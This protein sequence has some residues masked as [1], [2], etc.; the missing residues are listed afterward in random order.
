MLR[1]AQTL[2]QYCQCLTQNR[3]RSECVFGEHVEQQECRI[4][5]KNTF[6][7]LLDTRKRVI[8][9]IQW[10]FYFQKASLKYLQFVQKHLKVSRTLHCKFNL[11]AHTWN[12]INISS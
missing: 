6:T 5:P 2:T 12:N 3:F 1:T 11:K 9:Q 7:S 4:T 10:L 8:A